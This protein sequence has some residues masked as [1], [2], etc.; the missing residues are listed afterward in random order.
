[1]S[2]KTAT[3]GFLLLAGSLFHFLFSLVARLMEKDMRYVSIEEIWGLEWIDSIP[4]SSIQPFVV[5]VATA[6]LYV[7]F[8]VLGVG[9]ILLSTFQKH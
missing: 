1:M 6:Q 3:F 4:I 9:F 2:N 8:L 7:I 5:S